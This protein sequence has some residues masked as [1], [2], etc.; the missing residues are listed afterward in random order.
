MIDDDLRLIISFGTAGKLTTNAQYGTGFNPFD[1]ETVIDSAKCVEIANNANLLLKCINIIV[2]NNKE[3]KNKNTIRSII[4]NKDSEPIRIDHPFLLEVFSYD[5][6]GYLRKAKNYDDLDPDNDDYFFYI[7]FSFLRYITSP[8]TLEKIQ[9]ILEAGNINDVVKNIGYSSFSDLIEVADLLDPIVKSGTLD[10]IINSDKFYKLINLSDNKV[11]QWLSDNLFEK[12]WPENL[13][14]SFILAISFNKEVLLNIINENNESSAINNIDNALNT[15]F[16]KNTENEYKIDGAILFEDFK[17]WI[18][19]NT[20]A[21]L[22]EGIGEKLYKIIKKIEQDCL[23]DIKRKALQLNNVYKINLEIDDDLFKDF[24]ASDLFINNYNLG[25]YY[26]KNISKDSDIINIM[27]SFFE[28]NKTIFFQNGKIDLFHFFTE[29]NNYLPTILDDKTLISLFAGGDFNFIKERIEISLNIQSVNKIVNDGVS[30]NIRNAF[31]NNEEFSKAYYSAKEGEVINISNLISPEQR[32]LI[33]IKNGSKKGIYSYRESLETIK[34]SILDLKKSSSP[35]KKIV[36]DDILNDYFDNL[37]EVLIRQLKTEELFLQGKTNTFGMT[38]LIKNDISYEKEEENFYDDSFDFSNITENSFFKTLESFHNQ[39]F[40][41]FSNICLY[42]QIFKNEAVEFFSSKDINSIKSSLVKLLNFL[43]SKNSKADNNMDLIKKNYSL[44]VNIYNS[45]YNYEPSIDIVND[46]Y[47]DSKNKT[48]K[49]YIEMIS[50]PLQLL[51]NFSNISPIVLQSIFNS[52]TFKKTHDQN[53]FEIQNLVIPM[54]GKREYIAIIKIIKKDKKDISKYITEDVE[55]FF[56]LIKNIKSPEEYDLA[57]KSLIGDGS[58]NVFRT[59]KFAL[60]YI[61]N[62]NDISN[63]IDSAEPK[64]PAIFAPNLET[65]NFRFTVLEDKDPRHF[66]VGVETDCCQTIGGVGE[67][68]AIDS[69]IN[70]YAGVLLLESK[71]TKDWELAA[72]SYFHYAELEGGEKAIILDNIEAGKLT[73]IYKKEFYRDAYATLGEYL[74]KS[75]FKIVGCGKSQTVVFNSNDFELGSL[76]RDPRYFEIRKHK[77]RPYTDF[78]NKSFYD[79]TKPKFDFKQSKNIIENKG[80]LSKLSLNILSFY[81]EKY[82]SNIT[83]K[84]LKISKLLEKN[85]F[86]KEAAQIVSI[87]IIK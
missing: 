66:S 50:N 19:I 69:F 15:Y 64:D 3:F 70:P 26:T 76:N 75:G 81:I 42:F 36:S 63:W 47:K 57:I 52:E 77:K 9:K 21:F 2:E 27:V 35:L 78:D 54:L 23:D 72:Q 1:V 55:R 33:M 79:L 53:I 7:P 31:L 13:K 71:S 74:S 59:I 14:K 84:I 87:A 61:K 39:L 85:G 38:E 73:H 12:L 41:N 62:F 56:S 44:N 60:G 10:K 16:Q 34:H 65:E 25:K 58:T 29:F 43:N 24:K 51:H 45:N 8:K 32:R 11:I 30:K 40:N 68:A 49:E 46:I 48:K 37:Q 28:Q 22:K 20:K 67:A 80:E 83:K 5:N 86:K 18:E 6:M 4:W 17:K 82:G